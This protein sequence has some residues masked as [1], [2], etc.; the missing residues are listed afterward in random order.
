[1]S[2]CVYPNP[3]SPDDAE[4]VDRLAYVLTTADHPT[5]GTWNLVSRQMVRLLRQVYPRMDAG[6]L[7]RSFLVSDGT[8]S[9]VVARIAADNRYL[10]E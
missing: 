8:M 5:I 10:V 9:A 2:R 1:M 6:R 3:S 7:W 4:L